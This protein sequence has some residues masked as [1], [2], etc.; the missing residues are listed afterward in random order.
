MMLFKLPQFLRALQDY[1]LTDFVEKTKKQK[2]SFMT[3]KL[4][5]WLE[6][7]DAVG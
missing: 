1:L 4:P 7:K 5:E 6:M 2:N 3:E